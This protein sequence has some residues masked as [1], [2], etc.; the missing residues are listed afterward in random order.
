[1]KSI[2]KVAILTSFLCLGL[3]GTAFAGGIGTEAG[4]DLAPTPYTLAAAENHHYDQAKLAQQATE[5]GVD[6]VP[7]AK[8]LAAAENHVYDQNRLAQIGTEAGV[9]T[10]GRGNA[11]VDCALC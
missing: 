10:W 7:S 5:A 1:M 3:F 8:T 4:I 11:P 2:I 6:L 9:D